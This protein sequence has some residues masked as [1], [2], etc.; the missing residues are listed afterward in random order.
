MLDDLEGLG[1]PLGKK[2]KFLS[3]LELA[4][5]KLSIY[6]R[7]LFK[8]TLNCGENKKRGCI[9]N[10]EKQ[11]WDGEANGQKNMTS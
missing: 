3:R 5:S 8:S 4:R 1:S 6:Q 9:S 7:D 11:K 10:Q 2:R